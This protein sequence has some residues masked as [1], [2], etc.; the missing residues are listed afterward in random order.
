MLRLADASVSYQVQILDTTFY[1]K[2]LSILERQTLLED[3]TTLRESASSFEKIIDILCSIIVRIDGY[4]DVRKTLS[5]LELVQDLIIIIKAVVNESSLP[6]I[7][8]KN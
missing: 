8:R 2:S 1:V 6:E 5:S 7:E 3:I 4:E